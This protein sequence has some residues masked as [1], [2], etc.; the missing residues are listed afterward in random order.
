[1][2][3]DVLIQVTEPSG[4]TSL[5]KTTG[6]NVDT[7][8]EYDSADHL[9]KATTQ[10]QTRIF[11]YDHRGF[12]TLEQHPEVGGEWQPSRSGMYLTGLR[13]E[14]VGYDARGHAHGKLTGTLNGL[15]LDLRY[16]YD[17]SERLLKVFDSGDTKRSLK[18]YSLLDRHDS[19]PPQPR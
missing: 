5:V 9:T 19:H 10:S 18:E 14:Q 7:M 13:T 11:T 17:P 2:P 12:L 6:D 15:P 4:N 3:W 8:Y 16:D 1:M